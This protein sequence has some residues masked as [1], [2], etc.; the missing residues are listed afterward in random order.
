MDTGKDPSLFYSQ[1]SM[2]IRILKTVMVMYVT[3]E[4]RTLKGMIVSGLEH[5]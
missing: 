5:A 3:A 2:G 4:Q 1:L